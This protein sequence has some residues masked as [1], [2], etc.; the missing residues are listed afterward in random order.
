MNKVNILY[1]VHNALDSP[2][3]EE[4]KFMHM[5]TYTQEEPI[6]LKG[7]AIIQDIKKRA[8]SYG[9][10]FKTFALAIPD[11]TPVWHNRL[12]S[13]FP[14]PW[15]NHNGRITLIGDAAH[16]MTFRKFTTHNTDS[17]NSKQ[18]RIIC[19]VGSVGSER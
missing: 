13:W 15:D 6:F 8:L 2:K 19:L 5:I 10:P 17:Q 9:E 7:P 16:A 11:D 3:P 4:W 18:I 14:K 12:P 1:V